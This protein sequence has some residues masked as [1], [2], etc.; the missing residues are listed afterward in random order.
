MA[1]TPTF[2]NYDLLG[3]K[4]A[5]KNGENITALLRQ[6]TDINTSEAIEIV[7]DLQAGSYVDA[8]RDDDSFHSTFGREAAGYIDEYI[9]AGDVI[10]DAGTGEMTILGFILQA[11]KTEI[12]KTYAFD[13]SW[14]R[15]QKGREYAYERWADLFKKVELFVADMKAVPLPD[16]SVDV[17]IT[18]HALES[19]GGSVDALLSELMRVTRR[20]LVLFEPCYELN[21][22]E[23]QQRMDR[24]GYIKG[25]DQ[26]VERLGGKL[27][28]RKKFDNIINPLNPTTCFVIEPPVSG[29]QNNPAF[30]VPGTSHLL[31]A[32]VDEFLFSNRVGVCFPV[33]KDV[34]SLK[35][36]N[37]IL[38]SS[39]LS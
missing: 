9:Q 11:L 30:S 24:L 3:L 32:K 7:Y 16:N 8:I 23:G 18:N 6:K 19:N 4:E 5:F 17:T 22:P 39:L 20:K 36:A 33:L 14:S 29:V 35:P 21:S 12:T 27:L 15:I 10:L 2:F 1:Q 34:P 25:L 28:E 38:A 31:D 26:A 37:A 13:I